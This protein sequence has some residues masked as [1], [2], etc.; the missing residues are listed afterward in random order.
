MEDDIKKKYEKGVELFY[1]HCGKV[2]VE[3]EMMC[4]FLR[5]NILS[6][7]ETDGLKSQDLSRIMMADLSAYLLISKF[8]AIYALAYEN[9]PIKID[10]LDPFFKAL[11]KIN[12]TRNFMVHGNWSIPP[13]N[14][15]NIMGDPELKSVFVSKDMI[16]KDGVSYEAKIFS[17]DDFKEIIV[18]IKKATKILHLIKSSH[19][20]KKNILEMVSS[21]SIN[22]LK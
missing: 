3:F 6:F 20:F 8:R 18:K 4:E 7:L 22:K 2:I 17:D 16:K 1:S 14:D 13:A 10:H 12:E 9:E 11:L 5:F 19:I 15:H 21:E